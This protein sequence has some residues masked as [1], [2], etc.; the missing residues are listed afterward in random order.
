MATPHCSPRLSSSQVGGG[1]CGGCGVSS[2]RC[3]L[4]GARGTR[5]PSCGNHARSYHPKGKP[6]PPHPPTP[7]PNNQHPCCTPPHPTPPHPTPPVQ[8]SCPSTLGGRACLA[9][10]PSWRPGGR[11]SRRTQRRRGWLGRCGRGW[12]TG[13]RPSGGTTWASRRRWQTAPS[14]GHAPRQNNTTQHNTTLRLGP[15][16][17]QAQLSGGGR[18]QPRGG[19]APLSRGTHAHALPPHA[20]SSPRRPQPTCCCRSTPPLL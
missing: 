10:G 17:K 9:G 11:R 3:A 18:E 13:S 1:R 4:L 2:G 20:R 16:N 7:T 6:S 19:A 14:T 15:P 5:A 12:Q 8:K